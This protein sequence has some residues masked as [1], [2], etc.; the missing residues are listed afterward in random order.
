M[1]SQPKKKILILGG[2]GFLGAN[3]VRRCLKEPGVTVTVV[4]SLDPVLKSTTENLKRVWDRITFVQ[5]D[6]RDDAVLKQHVP[7]KDLIFNCAAQ[8]SHP[9]SLENP[10]YD[11]E[12]NCV[13]TLKVLLAVRDTNPGAVVVY[14]S[15]S[16]MIGKA[17]QDVIDEA[18]GEKPLDIYSANKGVAEKYHRIFH[19]VYDLKTVVLR[20]AN[21]YGP[22]GKSDSAFGFMNYFIHLA[23]GNKPITVF[24]DGGQTRNVMFVDDATDIM[25]RSTE[26]PELFG[27]TYFAAHTDHHSVKEIAD[28]VVSAFGT[29]VVKSIPWPDVRKRIEIEKVLISSA[30]IQGLTGWKAKYD[31]Y[32]GL[33]LTKERMISGKY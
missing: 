12:V 7:G 16:T 32:E 4:D 31:L 10:T 18:H 22:L 14:P 11:A 21:L 27:E 30:R 29:G 28:A 20:F 6:I 26:I 1:T 3:L 2:A 23:S 15:S 24:G 13:G 17:V 5:G 19:T 9:Y 25:V 33:K 8:S